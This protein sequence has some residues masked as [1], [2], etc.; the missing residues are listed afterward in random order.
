M[1]AHGLG[2][3]PL[4][5]GKARFYPDANLSSIAVISIVASVGGLET[6]TRANDDGVEDDTHIHTETHG[7]ASCP[8]QGFGCSGGEGT[9]W[10]SLHSFGARTVLPI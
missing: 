7:S 10:R 2:R 5:T 3:R 6:D 9:D 1:W 4:F 8:H